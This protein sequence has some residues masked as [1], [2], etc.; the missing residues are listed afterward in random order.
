MENAPTRVSQLENSLCVF[1]D[2]DREERRWAKYSRT[3]LKKNQSAIGVSKMEGTP[4]R[5]FVSLTR[6]A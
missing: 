6:K 5:V 1:R 2:L 4:R 3:G